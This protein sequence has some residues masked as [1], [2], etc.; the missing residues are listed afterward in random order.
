MMLIVLP[1]VE[2]F[3]YLLAHPTVLK[4]VTTDFK[5]KFGTWMISADIVD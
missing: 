1:R 2:S 5:R 3:S 4:A